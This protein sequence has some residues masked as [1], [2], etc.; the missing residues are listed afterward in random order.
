MVDVGFG[1][2]RPTKPITLTDGSVTRNLGTQEVKLK[3]ENITRISI[4]RRNCGCI[5]LATVRRMI[6][7]IAVRFNHAT[8]CQHCGQRR[9]RDVSV[10][11]T[12]ICD[13]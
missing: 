3:Y 6:G 7:K 1:G 2:D 8:T 10:V 13:Y 11:W 5:R 12:L 9:V 4:R